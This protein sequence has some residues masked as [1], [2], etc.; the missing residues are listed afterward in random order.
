MAANATNFDKDL[1]LLLERLDYRPGSGWISAAHFEGQSAHRF[2]MQQAHREMSV[3]GAFSLMTHSVKR[4]GS[5]TPLVY[6][7]KAHDQSSAQEIHR[8]VW[9]QGLAPFLLVGTPAGVFI[10]SGFSYAPRDW[11]KSVR[12]FTWADVRALP[13]E[14]TATTGFPEALSELWDL[15]A[16]R[17][18]TSLF[19]R[20]HAIDVDGRVDQSLLKNL[21]ALS[22]LLIQGADVSCKLS[23]AG[24]NGL[25]GRFLYVYFLYDRG[26][27]DQHWVSK[28]KHRHIDIENQNVDWPAAATWTF[29]DDLDAIFNGS[30]FPLKKE[31]RAKI[32][33]THINLVR[34]VMKHGAQPVGS[35]AVQLSFLDFYLGALRTETLSSVYEQFLENIRA[36]ER[37]RVGAFYTPPFLVDFMLDRIEEECVF[38]DGVRVLDPSAGSGVFLVGVFRRI[39]ERS[40]ATGTMDLATLR[41]LLT[42]NIFGIERN[43]DA[44]HVAAFSLY[45]TMLDYVDPRDLNQIAAGRAQ[46][47]LFPALVDRNLHARDFFSDAK[48]FPGLPAEFD[49]VVGNPPWQSLDKLDSL[50]ADQ[51]KQREQ[52][53]VG[54]NQAAELFVWKALREHLKAG[55]VLGFLLPAKTFINPTSLDFRRELTSSFRI[56]GAANFAHLRYRLFESAR[57]AVVAAFI[58]AT[59]PTPRDRV[60]TYSPLSI[61]QPMARKAWPWTILLDRAD[62]QVFNHDHVARNPRGWF[63]AF[64]LRPVDRQI[65]QF[66]DDAAELGE[67][68]LLEDLCDRVGAAVRRGGNEIETGVERSFLI[69]APGEVSAVDLFRRAI[70]GEAAGRDRADAALPPAQLARVTPAYRDRFGGNVLLIPRNFSSVRFVP[71]PIGYTSSTLAVFFKKSANL[72]TPRE[73][74]LLRALALYLRSPVALYLVATTGR[75]WLMDRRNIEPTD[76]QALP[77]PFT[78]LDDKRIDEVLEAPSE[79][80]NALVL[81]MLGLSGDYERAIREFLDFRMGFQDGDVPAEAIR[82]PSQKSVRAYEGVLRRNLDGLLGRKG[83]F[84]VVSKIDQQI[85]IAAVAA[86]FVQPG[87]SLEKSASDACERLLRRFERSAEN[88]FA[89]SLVIAR[90]EGASSVTFIKPFEYY[91]WTVEAAFADSRQIMD[92]F[93]AMKS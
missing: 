72:V 92:A 48:D 11:L 31:D 88:N 45:L 67:I 63:E 55:G 39:V 2:A 22:K 16:L 42:R 93:V 65:R 76:A 36:G 57:Q 17:L 1:D 60:W 32:D 8:K 77:V 84:S 66:L 26:I 43:V 13:T 28:R 37:R 79:N 3:I 47:K 27:I 89:N 74:K 9:S 5:S 20:D 33:H 50:A 87:A 90:E 35:G 25:I 44:C 82:T 86:E 73:K 15:R 59:K 81:S 4:Q 24:A 61:S 78:G 7:A 91:R 53:V 56:V 19:W 83:A 70:D 10:C 6:V 62:V 29:F 49:C 71:R 23:P 69:D 46:E 51:W 58:R 54:A 80:L 12:R 14:P 21:N 38:E 75:R 18:R 85:G 40:R 30:I 52:A 41:K 64:V 34:R 68:S